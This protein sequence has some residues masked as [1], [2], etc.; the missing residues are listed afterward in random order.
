[1][2]EGTT[3]PKHY[4]IMS[5]TGQPDDKQNSFMYVLEMCCMICAAGYLQLNKDFV[6]V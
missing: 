1:M 4:I 3:E 5:V 2:P 6:S